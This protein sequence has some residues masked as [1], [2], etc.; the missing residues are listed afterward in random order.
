MAGSA[1]P[2]VII[3]RVQKQNKIIFI[4]TQFIFKSTYSF[5]YGFLETH[6]ITTQESD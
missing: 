5:M 1:V 6:F 3:S 4:I 2:T